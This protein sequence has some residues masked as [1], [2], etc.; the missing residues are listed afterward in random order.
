M[1]RIQHNPHKHA[2][3]RARHRNRHKPRKHQKRHPL[4][5]NRLVRAIRQTD[6]DGRARDA[7]GRTDGQGVLREE[8]DGD[9]GAHF[10]GGTYGCISII[11]LL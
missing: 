7:H 11:L 3:N 2:P 5:V 10:H 9:G 6:S 1:R 4:E 8:Q